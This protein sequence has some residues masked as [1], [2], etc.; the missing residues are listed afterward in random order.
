MYIYMHSYDDMHHRIACIHT[1]IV[2][3][4]CSYR[5]WSYDDESS[6]SIII[7]IH[8]FVVCTSVHTRWSLFNRSSTMISLHRDHDSSWRGITRSQRSIIERYSCRDVQPRIAIGALMHM[9]FHHLM[10]FNAMHQSIERSTTRTTIVE[11]YRTLRRVQRLWISIHHTI[12]KDN[13][14]FITH[15]RSLFINRYHWRL[16]DV[17]LQ[18]KLYVQSLNV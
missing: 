9:A 2:L 3:N 6:Y 1:S 17:S 12:F 15:C 18:D 5:W 10:W 16:Y 7:R 8:W 4:E 11:L 13:S 14:I